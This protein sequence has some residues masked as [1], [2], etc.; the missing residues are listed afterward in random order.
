LARPDPACLVPI[1]PGKAGLS[2]KNLPGVVASDSIKF[3][4][5]RG[6]AV[7]PVEFGTAPFVFELCGGG[8]GMRSRA[9]GTS[10]GRAQIRRR[11]AVAGASGIW[12]GHEPAPLPAPAS[13]MGT[14]PDPARRT[15]LASDRRK[16]GSGGALDRTGD[17]GIMRPA[18][19]ATPAVSVHAGR[20]ILAFFR[21]RR[22]WSG[23]RRRENRH[24]SGTVTS[25]LTDHA[26][27][28]PCA[29]EQG[30]P[31][32]WSVHRSIHS[33]PQTVQRRW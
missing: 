24:R 5:G 30:A 32:Q 2:I 10:G 27:P 19:A 7:D 9:R 16:T 33:C 3:T 28:G 22:G 23:L 13:P 11:C 4:W 18:A 26:R 25:M 15:N 21:Q 12:S 17:L 20:K 1:L 29:P 6:P 8:L 31:A 14:G